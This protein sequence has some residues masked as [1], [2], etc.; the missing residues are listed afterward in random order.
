MITSGPADPVAG[1]A[2]GG[3]N[4]DLELRVYNPRKVSVGTPMLIV[5]VLNEDGR[6][7][8]LRPAELL[9]RVHTAGRRD[10]WQI[11]P[12]VF[13]ESPDGASN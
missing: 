13:T 3:A 4:H 2:S 7:W 10:D 6:T 11:V 1:L 12:I 8:R 5:G 9:A